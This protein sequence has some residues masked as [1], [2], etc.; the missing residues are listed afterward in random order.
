MA[1]FEAPERGRVTLHFT[2]DLAGLEV[3]VLE[4]PEAA[5]RCAARLTEL[6]DAQ[7]ITAADA[8]IVLELFDTFAAHLVSWNV[9]V[10]KEPV[11]AT[12]SGVGRLADEFVLSIIMAW[13]TTVTGGGTSAL[14]QSAREDADLAASLTMEPLS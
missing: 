6:S 14:A 12:R 3:T 13:L 11:P 1:G 2:G 7:E 5:L 9:T 10:R 8:K 4:A